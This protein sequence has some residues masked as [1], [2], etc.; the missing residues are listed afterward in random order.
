MMDPELQKVLLA[1]HQEVEDMTVKYIPPEPYDKYLLVSTCFACPEQY[2][3]FIKDTNQQVAY[4]RLRHGTFRV[5]VPDCGGET[6]YLARPKG[7]GC[8]DTD[9]REFYLT[10]ALKAVDTYYE[11]LT[12]SKK[13]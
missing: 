10:E 6:V 3:L 1:L 5:D 2:D 9:E 13:S 7:D 4:F 8:F 11:N 12:N